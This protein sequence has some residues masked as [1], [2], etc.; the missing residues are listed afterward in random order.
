MYVSI[1]QPNRMKIEIIGRI[2]TGRHNAAW[3][4]S[5]FSCI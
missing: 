3:A 5:L 4:P 2:T 1:K